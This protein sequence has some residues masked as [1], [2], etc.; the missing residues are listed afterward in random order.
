MRKIWV[1]GKEE[2]NKYKFI[3]YFLYIIWY[4]SLDLNFG[5]IYCIEI[6]LWRREGGLRFRRVEECSVV[7]K[8]VMGF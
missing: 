1:R 5:K 4:K 8:I 2:I 3:E 6:E 7:D